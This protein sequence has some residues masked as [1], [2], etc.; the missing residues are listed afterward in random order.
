VVWAGLLAG[1]IVLLMGGVLWFAPQQ[2]TLAGLIAVIFSVGSFISTNLGGFF[3]GM[4]LGILGGAMG[5]SWAPL[6]ARV[7]KQVAGE[8]ETGTG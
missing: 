8:P 6:K 3:I 1:A 7:T 5:F 4:L 2:R